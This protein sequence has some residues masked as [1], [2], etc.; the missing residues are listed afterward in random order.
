[1]SV[2]QRAEP[3]RSRFDVLDP[4]A[5]VTIAVLALALVWVM[6]SWASGGAAITAEHQ[7]RLSAEDQ[8]AA[9]ATEIA[10]LRPTPA[11][12]MCWEGTTR[13]TC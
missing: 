9:Q 5:Y 13:V 3:A 11:P 10:Q 7:A 8:V 12:N 2:M 1:M 4:L 6:L